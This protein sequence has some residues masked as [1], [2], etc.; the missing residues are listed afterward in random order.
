MQ[1]VLP[2]DSPNHPIQQSRMVLRRLLKAV[3]EWREV[4]DELRRDVDDILKSSRA[5]MRRADEV[6]LG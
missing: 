6:R 4:N 1:P 5:A 2:L 3:A